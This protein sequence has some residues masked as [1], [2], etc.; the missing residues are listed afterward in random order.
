MADRN[1]LGQ[2][3]PGMSGNAG[4]RPKLIGEVRDLA[5]QFTEEAVETLASIMRNPESPTPARVAA[6]QALLDRGWGRA[7]Q[8]V[9]VQRSGGFAEMLEQL[10]QRQQP[11]D[12]T[13]KVEEIN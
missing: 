5:R 9:E 3:L 1:E 10:E 11:R 13:P 6:A 12:I 8:Q 2:F 7:A 4:G